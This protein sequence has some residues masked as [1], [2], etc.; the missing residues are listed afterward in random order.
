MN[1]KIKTI[2]KEQKTIIREA[3]ISA[4]IKELLLTHSIDLTTYYKI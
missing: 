1:D 3:V 2:N 4:M